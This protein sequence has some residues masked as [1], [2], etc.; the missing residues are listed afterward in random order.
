[1]LDTRPSKSTYTRSIGGGRLVPVV[2]GVQRDTFARGL[3]GNFVGLTGTWLACMD[4]HHGVQPFGVCIAVAGPFRG[5]VGG[6]SGDALAR[7]LKGVVSF[8]RLGRFVAPDCVE[9]PCLPLGL[10]GVFG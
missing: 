2:T 10:A 5:V 6:A 3:E 1:M 8:T 4:R 9:G 7:P